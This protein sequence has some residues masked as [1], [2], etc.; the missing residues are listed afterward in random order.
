MHSLQQRLIAAGFAPTLISVGP[1]PTA[2][3][4]PIAEA[5]DEIRPGN[6]ALL[7][8]TAWR[9]GLCSPDAMAL[10]AVTRVVAV[11]PHFAIIDA[12]SEMFSSDKGPHGTRA[13]G[14]GIAV[15]QYGEQYEILK[16]SEEH[17]FLSY[18]DQT[19]ERGA[20]L[21]IFPNHSCAVVAQSERAV[22]RQPYGSAEMLDIQGR[23]KFI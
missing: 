17:G 7:N 12:G 20:L 16:L 23:G 9:L 5:S 15:D 4:A 19:P 8:L 10:S 22:L 11:N 3:A 14:F 1:I 13:S 6:Y 21:R 2:L 18:R